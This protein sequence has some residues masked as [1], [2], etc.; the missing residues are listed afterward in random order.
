MLRREVPPPPGLS[1]PSSARENSLVGA[2]RLSRLRSPS[3]PALCQAP[4]SK[5]RHAPSTT[6]RMSEAPRKGGGDAWIGGGTRRRRNL[7]GV[8][9][10]RP[11]SKVHGAAGPKHGGIF[12][13]AVS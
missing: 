4:A 13:G 10:K 2:V 8:A 7:W 5:G 6:A 1:S 9:G 3:A 11:S 12:D